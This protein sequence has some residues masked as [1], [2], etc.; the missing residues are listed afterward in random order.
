[1]SS[2]QSTR[3][4]V[5]GATFEQVVLSGLASDKGLF[6]PET[7]P[8]I[9]E[10]ALQDWKDL[11]YNE[12]ALKVMQLFISTDEIPSDDLKTIIDR[13]YNSRNFRHSDVVPIVPVSD[14]SVMELFHGPTFAFKDIALQFLGNLFEYFLAR[15]NKTSKERYSMTVVGATSGDTGS[16][17]IYGLRGKSDIEVFILYPEGKVSD[18][19]EK[20]MISVLDSNIH[21]LAVQGTFD[22]CQAVV[23]GLFGDAEFKR[24]Y[25]L[26]AVNSINFAR[27]LAQIV[28]Y[29]YAYFRLQEEYRGKVSKVSFSVPT[30]NFGDILAGYYAKRLGLPVDDLIVATNDNDILHRFFTTG[31]YHRAG[32]SHTIS[33]SMDICVSSNFERFLF[34]IAGDDSEQLVRWMN[35]FETTGKLTI[36]GDLLKKAQE[37]M[38][39]CRVSEATI[40]Q[41]I[42]SV[43]KTE[44]YLL[45]PH[46]SIG[47]KAAE[48]M[49]TT[50]SPMVVVGT[51]HY[52]KFLPTVVRAIYN[53]D[54]IFE[55]PIKQHPILE[56]IKHLP[57]RNTVVQ[58]DITLIREQIEA[59]VKSRRRFAWINPTSSAVTGA[60]TAAV[61][62]VAWYLLKR[63]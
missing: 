36:Q 13:S 32:V 58:N 5:R 34:G 15:K 57:T 20:Q 53:H 24:K 56:A 37:Q 12:L 29:F 55:T 60:A 40:L 6:V 7:F 11:S 54:R 52:G 43:W 26:G 62:L 22:D 2:F 35:E 48:E 49:K 25:K 44:Q 45:D 41:T 14:M 18:I 51:A 47:Y 33:P 10:N 16:S 61:G 21:N 31:K 38:K 59:T 63:K 30:G 8:S 28:Y 27:I 19:Q 9:P 46:T 23:K 17:A 42:R 50:S 4:G 39:S 1:M 3:G